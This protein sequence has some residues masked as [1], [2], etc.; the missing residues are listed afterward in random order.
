MKKMAEIADLNA[1]VKAFAREKE[2]D[3]VGIASVDSYEGVDETMHPR[4]WV[5][6]AQAVICLALQVPK[7]LVMQVVNRK[8]P[9][10]Y[11]RFGT[12][13]LNDELDTIANQVSRFLARQGYECLPTPAN[14]WRDPRTLKPMISHVMTAVAAGLGEVGWNNLLL[15]PQFGPRQKLVTVI[16][17]APLVPDSVYSGD[18]IC[19]HCMACV[20]ACQIGALA[21]DRTRSVTIGGQSFEW[22]SLRR[23]KCIW[24]CQGITSHGTFSGG[25][26]FY[27]RDVPFP[28]KTPTP[29]QIIEL[30]ESQPPWATG[31]GARC[32][33]VCNPNPEMAKKR[34]AKEQAVQPAG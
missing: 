4:Y 19:D 17:N 22:G 28:E 18:P 10:P 24:E 7:P 29:E 20:E 26:G 16:T 31:C 15:T 32:L 5:P 25:V 34:R 9:W 13:I 1:D 30:Q 6:D 8:T 23:L 14:L 12:V 11:Y 33:A 27:S 21:E 3:L 2:V